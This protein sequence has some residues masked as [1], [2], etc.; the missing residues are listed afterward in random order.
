VKHRSVWHTVPQKYERFSDLEVVQVGSHFCWEG[1]TVR[2][3][4]ESAENPKQDVAILLKAWVDQLP[5]C[6]CCCWHGVM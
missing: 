4:E 5:V 3:G 1:R 2:S 6:C